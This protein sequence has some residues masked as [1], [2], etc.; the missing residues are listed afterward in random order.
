MN[1]LRTGYKEQWVT[2]PQLFILWNNE[3]VEHLLSDA[4]WT[5]TNDQLISPRKIKNLFFNAPD[6]YD[7]EHDKKSNLTKTC[8]S[9]KD[10][11]EKKGNGAS[12]CRGCW[13]KLCRRSE[14]ICSGHENRKQL[15]CTMHS[16]AG[17][18]PILSQWVMFSVKVICLAVSACDDTVVLSTTA[19][20][21]SQWAYSSEINKFG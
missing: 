20:Y 10:N 17:E 19:C 16:R 1:K 2:I 21:M 11:I 15:L 4:S 12:G 7:F 13:W 18:L 9:R 6:E 5:G 14:A 8:M 3:S